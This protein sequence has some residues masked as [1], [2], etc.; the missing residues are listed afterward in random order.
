LN[1]RLF[2]FFALVTADGQRPNPPAQS[3]CH[4]KSFFSSLSP[5]LS[6]SLSLSLFSF[7]PHN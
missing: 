2:F 6:L 1:F 4:R 7:K 3:R 5:S